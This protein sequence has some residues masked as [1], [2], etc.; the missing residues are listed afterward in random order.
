MPV[1]KTRERRRTKRRNRK[2]AKL[3]RLRD[4]IST[5]VKTLP[6]KS[7]L[8]VGT[9]DG[10]PTYTSKPMRSMTGAEGAAKRWVRHEAVRLVERQS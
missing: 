3:N 9:V 4:R 5:E 1:L 7:L 8:V 10:Q 6:D 2:E